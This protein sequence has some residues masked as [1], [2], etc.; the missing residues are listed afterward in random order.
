MWETLDSQKAIEPWYALCSRG[1]LLTAT[2]SWWVR[3]L[4]PALWD[5]I[6]ISNI[7]PF[8]LNSSTSRVLVYWTIY[9]W[10]QKTV[11]YSIVCNINHIQ[12]CKPKSLVTQLVKNP[13]AVQDTWV[14]SLGWEASLEKGYATHSSI[15]AWRIPWTAQP[16]GSQRVGHD[17]ETFTFKLPL[18]EECLNKLVHLHN[19]VWC[20]H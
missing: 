16:M 19:G 5:S 12:N 1:D 8:L 17:W 7:H 14:Q 11:H 10:A 13:P 15:L 18:K 4:V 3:M 6:K 2:S 20:S 9:T